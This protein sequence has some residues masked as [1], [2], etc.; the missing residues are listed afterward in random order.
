[1]SKSAFFEGG[2]P[3][4]AQISEGRRR[5]PPTTV[6]VRKLEWLSFHVVSTYPQCIVWS[7]HKARVWQTNRRTDRIRTPKTALA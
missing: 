5:R 7:C 3:L 6:G 4:S 2:R 1:M